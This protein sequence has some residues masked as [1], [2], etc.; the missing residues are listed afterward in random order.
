[1]KDAYAGLSFSQPKLEKR[2]PRAWSRHVLAGTVVVCSLLVALIMAEGILRLVSP[3]AVQVPYHD[4]LNGVLAARPNV[5]GQFAIPDT[6]NTTISVNSQRFRGLKEYSQTPEIGVTRIATLGDSFTFGFG[7]ND[8]ETYPAQLERH[9]N[10]SLSS[11]ARETK[12]EVINASVSGASTGDEALFFTTWVARFNPDLIV[13]NVHFN[14]VDENHQ[15]N[16]FEMD[17][18]GNVVPRPMRELG[19]ADSPVR[20][21]RG[22]VNALPLYS[23]LAQHSHLLY[24]FRHGATTALT[25][26][27]AASFQDEAE[28]G[29][30]SRAS[31]ESEGIPM[32]TAEIRWLNAQVRKARSRLVITFL[33]PQW[34]R[35]DAPPGYRWRS[36][37]IVNALVDLSTSEEI[38]FV[39]VTPLVRAREADVGRSLYYQGRDEHA[40]PM[41][42]EVYAEIISQYILSQNLI[43]LDTRD[44][45][46]AGN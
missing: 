14:D 28:I 9:L 4:E 5:R 46:A 27:R 26:I 41:G 37:V 33:P 10:Q 6:F 21:I 24:L 23:F 13:L 43:P 12:A 38:P 18:N 45:R 34:W 42:Y 16:M 8:E 3:Q 36:E 30:S 17:E 44:S 32:M 11:S 35:A 7:A 22:L 1:M 25:S 20:T 29:Y 2:L 19:S 40:N 39:D 15:R 31:F